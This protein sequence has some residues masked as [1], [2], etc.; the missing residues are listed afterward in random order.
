MEATV[1]VC[2][3]MGLASALLA[4]DSGACLGGVD[5]ACFMPAPAN[6][7]TLILSTVTLVPVIVCLFTAWLDARDGPNGEQQPLLYAG[8]LL[9]DGS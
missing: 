9:H 3:V 6:M 8:P 5:E 2:L 1:L 7:V 4:L